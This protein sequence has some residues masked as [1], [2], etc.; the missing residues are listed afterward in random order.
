MDPKSMKE[1][2]EI[3]IGQVVTVVNTQSYVRTLT[4]Y[5]VDVEVYKA[6][7]VSY[8]DQTLKIITEYIKDPRKK[9]KE[10]I[11]QFIPLSQV[12]R[13]TISSSEKFIAL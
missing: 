5:R 6:K 9:V 3:L 2:F 12:K 11:Y 13:V 8:E 4:G 7:V 10:K 1:A